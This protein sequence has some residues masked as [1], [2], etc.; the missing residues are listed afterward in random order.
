MAS[1]AALLV[2]AQHAGGAIAAK[3]WREKPACRSTGNSHNLHE[4]DMDQPLAGR[5]RAAVKRM[6]ANNKK[7]AFQTGGW[8]EGAAMQTDHVQHLTSIG[9]RRARWDAIFIYAGC[10][11]AGAAFWGM[12]ARQIFVMVAAR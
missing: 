6:I 2:Y 1:V 8:V 11:V 5:L 10:L 12:V 3:A 9:R 7:K 4:Y